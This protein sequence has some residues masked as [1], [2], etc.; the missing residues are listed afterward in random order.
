LYD[1]VRFVSV[2]GRHLNG[3]PTTIEERTEALARLHGR[4]AAAIEAPPESAGH[5]PPAVVT[6][7][8]QD[9]LQRIRQSKGHEEFERLYDV[10]ALPGEDESRL[11][12]SLCAK[13][14][15]WTGRDADQ[16]DRLFRNSALM[17]PKW[18]EKH[19]ADGRTYGQ[20]TISFAIQGCHRVYMP[21]GIEKTDATP[22]LV[23]AVHGAAIGPSNEIGKRV[24]RH[25]LSNGINRDLTVAILQETVARHAKL[26]DEDVQQIVRLESAKHQVTG[27]GEDEVLEP[28][29]ISEVLSQTRADLVNPTPKVGTPFPSLNDRLGGGYAPGELISLAAISSA[30][31]DCICPRDRHPCREGWD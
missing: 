29:H 7:N 8:D 28:I 23:K 15:F 3:K 21:G 17:R 13:L 12:A 31:Q 5:A 24:A 1:S 10:G 18:D 16:M 22:Y 19:F 27:S 30:G 11:D 26:S 4:V 2:T 9:L 6:L 25:L 14:A 20:A